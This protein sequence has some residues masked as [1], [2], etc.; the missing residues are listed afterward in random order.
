MHQ[1]PL[2][3]AA[4]KGWGELPPHHG[5][6]H[7]LHPH[8]LGSYPP[9][10]LCLIMCH[11]FIPLQHL[12]LDIVRLYLAFEKSETDQGADLYFIR[13]TAPLSVVKTSIYLA[14]TVVSDLFIVRA[15][16]SFVRC[17]QATLSYIGAISYGMR[18][19]PSSF[20]Q[21]FY[22]SPTLVCPCL[23]FQ[24][25]H[26]YSTPCLGTGIGAVYTL[27]LVGSNV[28][29]NKEQ[30]RITNSFFSCTLALNAVCTGALFVLRCIGGQC[31]TFFRARAY[32]VPHLADSEADKRRQ[33]RF[34]PYA[35][36]RYR[37]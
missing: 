4:A 10:P 2:R 19:S 20:F 27:T 25:R 32:C 31:L 33:D 17:T 29:F 30:E 18:A 11:S 12:V 5:L 16:K 26:T 23:H 6:G 15:S 35:S 13:V 24:C 37:H 8:N 36:L 28:V 1:G 21:S 3:E 14:E 22:I 7:S 9:P 34:Q